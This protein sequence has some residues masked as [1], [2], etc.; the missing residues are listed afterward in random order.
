MTRLKTF[1]EIP[2][3]TTG[4][5]EYELL[6]HQRFAKQARE[7]MFQKNK[8]QSGR[9]KKAQQQERAIHDTENTDNCERRF[10]ADDHQ[11]IK[12]LYK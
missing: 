11:A 8:Y 6:T 4:D 5:T 9:G 7:W 12:H 3:I 10:L 1:A 2:T